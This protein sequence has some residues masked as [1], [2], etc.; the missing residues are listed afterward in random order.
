ML[1]YK[2]YVLCVVLLFICSQR[3][4]CVFVAFVVISMDNMSVCYIRYLCVTSYVVKTE[5]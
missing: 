5:Y 1:Y 2:Y 4:I 3:Y